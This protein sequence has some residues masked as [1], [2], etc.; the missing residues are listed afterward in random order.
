[1]QVELLGRDLGQRGSHPGSEIDLAGIDGDVSIGADGKKS[2]DFLDRDRF[3]GSHLLPPARGDTAG[4]PE[5]DQEGAFDELSASAGGPDM[6]EHGG[7]S[8]LGV[9]GRALHRADHAQMRSTATKI[10]GERLLYL[11]D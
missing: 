10:V 2:V 6:I 8:P 5:G 4:K 11:C 7:A 1:G 9:A 3:R